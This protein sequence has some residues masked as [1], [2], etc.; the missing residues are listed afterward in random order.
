MVSSIVVPCVSAASSA[1]NQAV[2]P[3]SDKNLVNFYGT[4]RLRFMVIRV[5]G[6]GAADAWLTVDVDGEHFI[7]TRFDWLYNL[8]GST[9]GEH[10]DKIY[11]RTYD[12]TNKV[13]IIRF[14]NIIQFRRHLLVKFRNEHDTDVATVSWFIAF[15]KLA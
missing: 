14:N 6:I 3:N 10:G 11:F 9:T 7:Y 2:N 13:F 4:G 8:L 5:E 15:D 12:T 1:G